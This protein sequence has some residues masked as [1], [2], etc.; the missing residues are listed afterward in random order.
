MGNQKS[1]SRHE[2]TPNALRWAWPWGR[3]GRP[4]R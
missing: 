4:S 3:G 2:T 1:T